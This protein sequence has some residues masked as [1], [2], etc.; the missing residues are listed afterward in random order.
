MYI[1]KT[2]ATYKTYPLF[3]SHITYNNICFIS[4]VLISS[5]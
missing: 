3:K 4:F 2:E 5:K 1:I